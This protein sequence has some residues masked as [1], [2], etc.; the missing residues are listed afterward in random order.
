M[1]QLQRGVVGMV[2][3]CFGLMAFADFDKPLS[4]LPGLAGAVM[5]GVVFYLVS[6]KFGNGG[7]DEQEETLNSKQAADNSVADFGEFYEK[8]SIK[9]RAKAIGPYYE[10][11]VD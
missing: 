1:N 8:I 3:L 9:E 4:N 7:G 5:L 2:G 11:I 10:D 6:S